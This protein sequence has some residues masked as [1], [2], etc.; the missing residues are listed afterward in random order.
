MKKGFTLI[1]MLGIITVL[2]VI[3]LV[4][5]PT[6]NRTLKTMK[7]NTDD[8]F[9]NNLKVSVET[10]VELNK[11]NYPELQTSGNSITV[12]IQE[13]YESNLLKGKYEGI[14]TNSTVTVVSQE[15]KTLKFYYRG[16]EIGI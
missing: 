3:L 7:E 5:F 10:Y 4:T 16:E 6:L 9:T 14:D 11:D 15:D 13:L 1:E 2:A 12:K 8:N